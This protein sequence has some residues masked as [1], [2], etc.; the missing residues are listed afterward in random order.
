MSTLGGIRI[1]PRFVEPLRF[2]VVTCLRQFKPLAVLE[3]DYRLRERV[4]IVIMLCNWEF[5]KLFQEC[6]SP[7]D[8]LSGVLG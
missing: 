7:T 2:V 6:R 4:N 1:H 5:G 3:V 8:R